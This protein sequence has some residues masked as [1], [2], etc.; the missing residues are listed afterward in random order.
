MSEERQGQ[1][2]SYLD[3]QNVGTQRIIGNKTEQKGT[4]STLGQKSSVG[5]LN[6]AGTDW[7]AGDIT[8]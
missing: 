6:N 1:A 3:T 5:L 4:K 2:V 8:A 7:R